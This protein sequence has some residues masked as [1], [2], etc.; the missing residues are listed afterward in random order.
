MWT[1]SFNRTAAPSKHE[2]HL[3]ERAFG[4]NHAASIVAIERNGWKPTPASM[5]DDIQMAC[6]DHGHGG[7]W[8]TTQGRWS[9]STRIKACY[10]TSFQGKGEA[11][12]YFDRFGNLTQRMTRVAVNGD[13]PKDTGTGFVEVAWLEL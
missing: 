9:A 6:V 7:L 3:A 8:P 1:S 2:C 12:P 4:V 13:L 11:K 5:L 10:P